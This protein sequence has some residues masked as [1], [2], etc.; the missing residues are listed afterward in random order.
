MLSKA[1]FIIFMKTPSGND[2]PMLTTVAH[3]KELIEVLRGS[4]GGTKPNYLDQCSSVR[5]RGDDLA[6]D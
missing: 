3:G 2:L 5:S 4:W 6:K 1:A